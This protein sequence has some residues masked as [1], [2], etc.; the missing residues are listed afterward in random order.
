MEAQEEDEDNESQYIHQRHKRFKVMVI[1]EDENQL[2]NNL[3]K[4]SNQMFEQE[5]KSQARPNSV[6]GSSMSSK[7]SFLDRE[8]NFQQMII[9]NDL[10]NRLDEDIDGPEEFDYNLHDLKITLSS[11]VGHY[12]V[13]TDSCLSKS[14]APQQMAQ[15]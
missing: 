5:L 1:E 2:P 7:N 4:P 9:S 12:L 6:K 14:E 10:Q 13:N 11:S 8:D 3:R 15:S